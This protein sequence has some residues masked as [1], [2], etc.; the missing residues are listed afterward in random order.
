MTI[1][2][3]GHPRQHPAPELQMLRQSHVGKEALESMP[4]GYRVPELSGDALEVQFTCSLTDGQAISLELHAPDGT[5]LAQV[6]CTADGVDFAGTHVPRAAGQPLQLHLFIDRSLL[7]LFL[8]DG[9]ACATTYI[10]CDTRN[11]T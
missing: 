2:D 6:R 11:S 4:L 10:D 7:E 1:G 9:Q 5:R 3:D 8:D